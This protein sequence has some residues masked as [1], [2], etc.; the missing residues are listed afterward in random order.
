MA[1]NTFSLNVITPEKVV[2]SNEVS[3]VTAHGSD[4]YM[5]ILAQHAALITTLEPGQL[6][7]T[8][9]DEKNSYIYREQRYYGGQKKQSNRSGRCC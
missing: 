8:E 7:I 4:G 3:A 1:E 6:S 2:Y 9:P 5:G